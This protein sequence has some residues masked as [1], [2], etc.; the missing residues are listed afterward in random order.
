MQIEL[1]YYAGLLKLLQPILDAGCASSLLDDW[2][3]FGRMSGKI[4]PDMP[5]Y[6]AIWLRYF[7]SNCQYMFAGDWQT[8]CAAFRER[9]CRNLCHLNGKMLKYAAI[10][11]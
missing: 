5:R 1:R 11:R 7:A 6:A 8:R 10:L 2:L 9:I 4:E 3:D